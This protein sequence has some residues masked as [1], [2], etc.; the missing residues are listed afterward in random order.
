MTAAPER[1]AL[2]RGR[3]WDPEGSLADSVGQYL[4]S[5]YQVT[6]TINA[7]TVEIVGHDHAGW[8]LEDYVI[9]RLWTGMFATEEIVD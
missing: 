9:P 8:T 1:R 4:P 7:D 6:R 5:N 3:P 2:V